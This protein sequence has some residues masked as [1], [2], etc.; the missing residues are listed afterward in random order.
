MN[1]RSFFES[2]CG[3]IRWHGEEGSAHCPLPGHG[4]RDNNPSFS[5]N[6]A[7]GTFF[8]HKERIGGGLKELAALTGQSLPEEQIKAGHDGGSRRIVAMY[9]Y[10]DAAGALL[11]QTV[12]FSPKGFAQR[13]PDPAQPGGWLWNLNGAAGSLSSSRPVGSAGRI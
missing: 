2:V 5:V 7:Q 8:C 13:R 6:A 9:D 3:P 10:T 4:G 1:S 11:Y 12:R